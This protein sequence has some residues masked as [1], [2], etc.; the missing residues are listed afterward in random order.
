MNLGDQAQEGLKIPLDLRVHGVELISQ[1]APV[2][3]PHGV[4]DV[5]ADTWGCGANWGNAECHDCHGPSPSAWARHCPAPMPVWYHVIRLLG[6][7]HHESS[8]WRRRPKQDGFGLT[9]TCPHAQ[10]PAH[11]NPCHPKQIA[12]E[13]EYPARYAVYP[14]YT[15]F[16]GAPRILSS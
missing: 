10:R 9:R 3:H 12:A 15:E 5:V 4:D 7:R 11:S 13:M 1:A 8:T 16:M 2:D 14:A 6:R